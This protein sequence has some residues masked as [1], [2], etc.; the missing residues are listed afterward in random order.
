MRR[1]RS[2]S[3]CY[4]DASSRYEEG[5]GIGKEKREGRRGKGEER[6]NDF[7]NL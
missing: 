7:I 2:R 3:F 5:I 4:E 6:A 1:T